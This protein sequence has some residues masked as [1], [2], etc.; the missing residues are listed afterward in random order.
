MAN[1]AVLSILRST[2]DAGP[3]TQIVGLRD[4]RDAWCKI[5]RVYSWTGAQ[6]TIRLWG[7]WV[8]TTYKSGGNAEAFLRKF[9]ENLQELHGVTKISE[10]IEIT[11]FMHAVS[12]VPE[13][14]P[15]INQVMLAQQDMATSSA[16]TLYNHFLH[17]TSQCRTQ[18]FQSNTTSVEKGKSGRGWGGSSSYKGGHHSSGNTHGKSEE[19]KNSIW[20]NYHETWGSHFSSTCCLKNEK[21]NNS[22]NNNSNTA[23]RGLLNT[24]GRPMCGR[25]SGG[26]T[27]GAN[28]TSHESTSNVQQNVSID[29]D[30]L[31]ANHT[32]LIIEG[33]P[34]HTDG[35]IFFA[36]QVDLSVN[37]MEAKIV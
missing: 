32:E 23:S 20:C 5:A 13:I 12:G 34:D 9:C 19:D 14:F 8:S 11:Q 18:T 29:N 2:L 22:N 30:T 27:A 36:N 31:W 25:G 37:S 1:F 6:S 7:V 26:H 4:A 15:F 16:A 35:G 28:A 10:I 21:G 33:A 17:Y 24:R 3:A